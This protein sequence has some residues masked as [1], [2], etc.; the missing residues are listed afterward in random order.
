MLEY[1]LF[2]AKT[3]TLVVALL[4][5]IGG[6][7]ALLS[8]SKS[9]KK[10]QLEIKDI[11]EKYK[12]FS[13]SFQQQVLPEHE[14]KQILKKEKSEKKAERKKQKKGE[15][16]PTKN[17]VFSL[18]F[19]GDIRA[20]ATDS[21]REEISAILMIA[22]KDDEVLVKVESGGGMVHSYG[23]AAS[24]LQRIRDRG[25]SLVISVDKVAASGGYMMAS[26]A[27][28][29]I[30]APFAVLGSIGVVMQ[31][32]NFNRLLK[33][34]NIDFEQITAGE[35]KRSLT[36]FGENTDADRKKTEE[37]LQETHDLFKEFILKNRSKL[38][39]ERIATGE[40]WYGTKALEL[41]LIDEVMTS[42]DYLMAKSKEN[43]LF[44]ISYS[45]KK[46]FMEKLP[47]RSEKG[48]KLFQSFTRLQEKLGITGI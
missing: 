45:P 33:Q 15:T 32:P 41:G 16:P 3:I 12:E 10:G 30:A 36:L 17:R 8:K 37:E 40:H 6:I 26:V 48:M 29:I 5:A 47:F 4:I 38:D 14:L 20:S 34:H 24:Q 13:K 42:D 27:N 39:I 9:H 19:H 35:H 22:R 1:G 21:M 2:L 31:L 28:K 7:V 46:T 44:E 25:I 11:N 18:T 23:L 43:D